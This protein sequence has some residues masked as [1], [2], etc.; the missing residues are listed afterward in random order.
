MTGHVHR[1]FSSPPSQLMLLDK[2]LCSKPTFQRGWKEHRCF[3]G[4]PQTLTWPEEVYHGFFLLSFHFK[5]KSGKVTTRPI[6]EDKS[7]P[8]HMLVACFHTQADTL[9]FF[10]LMLKHTNASVREERMFS[11]QNSSL[12]FVMPSRCQV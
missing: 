11:S 4:G 3:G 9:A 2:A 8:A 7:K 12:I 6:S 1:L 5:N 10:W